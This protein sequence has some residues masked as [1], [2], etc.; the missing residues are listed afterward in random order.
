MREKEVKKKTIGIIIL[1]ISL[2]NHTKKINLIPQ[3]QSGSFY[4]TI[5]SSIAPYFL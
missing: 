3:S 1:K 4:Q 5:F 2:L